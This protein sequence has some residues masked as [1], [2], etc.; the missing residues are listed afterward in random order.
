MSHDHQ[1]AAPSGS[2]GWA[3]RLICE[4]DENGVRLL[5]RRRV[6]KVVPPSDP[7]SST[8]QAIGFW[9]EVRD[10]QEQPLYA[11]VLSDPLTAEEEVPPPEGGGTFTNVVRTERSGTFALLVPDLDQSDHVS[12]MRRTY[13]S[14]TRATTRPAELAR[15]PLRGDATGNVEEET[16]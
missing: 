9:L 3:W 5:S 11:R 12:L 14:S 7:I 8:R 2:T 1:T 6:Q 4:H 16:R 10:A 13:S 15:L